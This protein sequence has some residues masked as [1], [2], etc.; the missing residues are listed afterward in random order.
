LGDQTA[1]AEK[2]PLAKQREY[3]FPPLLGGHDDFDLAPQNVEDG[4]CRV[5]LRENDA[6]ALILKF[7]SAA[8]RDR[9]EQ[10]RVKREAFDLPCLA[11][12]EPL[13]SAMPIVS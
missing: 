11:M 5:S 1:F 4:V 2:V 13:K 8:T 7:G 9:E 12:T 3:R 10:A 6:F